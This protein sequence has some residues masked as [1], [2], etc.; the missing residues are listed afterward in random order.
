M[1]ENMNSEVRRINFSQLSYEQFKNLPRDLKK[2]FLFW[3]ARTYGTARK[4]CIEQ[5]KDDTIYAQKRFSRYCI[6]NNL[7][8]IADI[9]HNNMHIP[10]IPKITT[11]P[12]SPDIK[13]TEKSIVP[14]KDVPTTPPR[15]TVA[16]ERIKNDVFNKTTIGLLKDYVVYLNNLIKELENKEM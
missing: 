15:V 2:E 4:L 16:I 6:I 10:K 12:A 7:P 13:V 5:F 11:E 1:Y 14:D 8:T 9:K 3:A